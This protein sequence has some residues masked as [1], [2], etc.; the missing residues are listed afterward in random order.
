[1]KTMKVMVR[2]DTG[3]WRRDSRPSGAGEAFTADSPGAAVR[4]I[5]LE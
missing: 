4:A 3:S 2:T 1:V 5:G